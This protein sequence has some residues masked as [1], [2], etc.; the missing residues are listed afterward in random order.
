MKFTKKSLGQ[1]FLIDK[2]IILK[3]INLIDL[4]DKNVIEIGPG[5]AALTNE[6][7]NKN[8]KTLSII[9]KDYDLAK[10]LKKQYLDTNKIKVYN[11]DILKF[12]LENLITNNSVIFGNLPYNI[13]S[14]ILIKILKFNSWPPKLS[15]IIFMFQKELGEKIIGKYNSPHYGRLSIISNYRLNILNKFLVSANCFFPKP[16]VKS[17][18]IHFQPKNILKFKIKDLNNLENVTNIIFSNKR[19]MINKSIKNILNDNEIKNIKKLKINSR[20]SEIPPEIYYQIT[21]LFE[22]K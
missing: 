7:L 18:V 17:M 16:K 14:Q 15:D 10:K 6:I 5:K 8:P 1:N 2:N 4:K 22:K 3:I 20:P 9:E 19:K 12:D 11:K 21:E 13:S